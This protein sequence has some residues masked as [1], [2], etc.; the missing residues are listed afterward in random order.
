MGWGERCLHLMTT[1]PRETHLLFRSW[2]GPPF[3]L[4]LGQFTAQLAPF[5]WTPGRE[6]PPRE[7]E[8]ESSQGYS[9]AMGPHSAPPLTTRGS[10]QALPSQGLSPLTCAIGYKDRPRGPSGM[11]DCENTFEK[12]NIGIIINSR[13]TKKGVFIE[14]WS[15]IG[16][17]LYFHQASV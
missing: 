17:C 15:F 1:Q 7:T 10:W 2:P 13:D 6:R 3:L 9:G 16:R 14:Y 4:H 11:L 12:I 5:R 8:V